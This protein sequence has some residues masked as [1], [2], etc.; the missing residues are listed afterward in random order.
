LKCQFRRKLLHAT[1]EV[2]Q[3]ISDW[4]NP[5]ILYLTWRYLVLDFKFRFQQ[6]SFWQPSNRTIHLDANSC[7]SSLSC[8][9][10]SLESK[11]SL[12]SD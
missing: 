4:I 7:Q 2:I 6:R 3:G 12:W 5:D 10:I 11:M 9:A 1:L 8:D